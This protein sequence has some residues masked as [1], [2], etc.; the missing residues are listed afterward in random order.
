MNSPHEVCYGAVRLAD[1]FQRIKIVKQN[2]KGCLMHKSTNTSCFRQLYGALAKPISDSTIL[3][4]TGSVQEL[5]SYVS[6]RLQ[7]IDGVFELCSDN[8]TKLAILDVETTS[9]LQ[10]LNRIE[11]TWS[12]AVV[13][14]RSIVKRPKSK[15]P[16]DLT[17]NVFGPRKAADEVSLALSRINVYLQH[18][19][20][21]DSEVEY[22]NPDMLVFPGDEPDMREYI[23][24]GTALWE[25]NHLIKDIENILGSLGQDAGPED[26]ELYPIDGLKSALTEFV[27]LYNH[28]RILQQRNQC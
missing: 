11:G 24:V 6:F 15:K 27:N 16:I 7:H 4:G 3:R 21:L 8:G 23:G 25:H 28:M 9:K 5:N 20:V 14:L 26:N 1:V 12:E 10:K 22:F 18:P 2:N 19:R 17:V 13:E